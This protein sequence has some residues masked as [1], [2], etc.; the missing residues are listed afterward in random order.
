MKS[1]FAALVPPG[2]VAQADDWIHILT[3]LRPLDAVELVAWFN[4]EVGRTAVRK[5]A[6][7]VGTLSVSKVSLAD[8]QIPAR[9]C[10][11]LAACRT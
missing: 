7:G 5:L 6:K 1:V 3:P 2:V 11:A 4:S 9:V 8:L 10:G